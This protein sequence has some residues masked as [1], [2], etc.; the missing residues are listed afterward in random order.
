MRIASMHVQ[1]YRSLYDARI[2]FDDQTAI[3]GRNSAGKSTVLNAI[4]LFY[5]LSA[6]LSEYDYFDRESNAEIRIQITFDDL[7]KPELDAFSSYVQDGT[8][9]VAKVIT[10]G[11]VR[12]VGSRLQIAEF[13]E[14]RAMSFRDQQ[15]RV[16]ELREK[17]E[18]E[19]LAGAI[20][21]QA[22]IATM[23]EDFEAANREKC[24]FIESE[25]QFLGPTNVGGGSLDNFTRFVAV[26]AVRDARS[27]L[28]R[29]G[30]I[31]KLLDVLIL[32]QLA[33]R[34]DVKEL[35]EQYEKRAAEIYSMDNLSELKELSSSISQCLHKYA[36]GVD[37]EIDF[38]ELKAPKLPT[39]DAVAFIS[40][41]QFSCP[42]S[43]VGHGVQRA[44]ILAVLEQ[45][46]AMEAKNHEGPDGEDL[47]PDLILAIEEPELYLHPSRCRYLCKTLTDLAASRS[48]SR[49]Q[50]IYTTHSP[51]FVGV[52]RFS[53]VRIASKK[54]VEATETKQSDLHWC[55]LD[56]VV[57]MI[58]DA[59]DDGTGGNFDVSG[60]SARS[61]TTMTLPVNEGF[62]A[63]VIVLV[64]GYSDAA[65]LE[66]AA[67]CSESAWDE[68]G[69][70]V[71]PVQGKGNIDKVFAVFESLRIPTYFCFDGDSH[72]ENEAQRT[73]NAKKNRCLLRIAGEQATDFPESE[74]LDRFAVFKNDLE[75]ELKGVDSDFFTV[76]RESIAKN[77]GVARQKDALKKPAG[78]RAYIES[79]YKEGKLPDSIIDIV[80]K[81]TE[82]RSTTP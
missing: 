67:H 42:I 82:I 48:D 20:N 23:L 56:H 4:S 25:G 24:E 7:K 29:Q 27:E 35:N 5:D 36:P 17:P 28:D 14:L 39:P 59:Q 18:F 69:V 54:P 66:T 80:S 51:L 13:A 70:A 65:A 64:E 8:L 73:E 79:A 11:G 15:A 45:L 63:D 71:I 53:Q 43:H 41:E 81:I 62:F 60:F 74:V 61:E 19:G 52:E 46:A 22:A 33:E 75:H 30:A 44:V 57:Q 38:G 72:Q 47:G 78:M 50:V 34:E 21:S 9:T 49:T 68:N 77:L 12:Y 58:A 1:G 31:H 76:T 32:R 55:S 2:D 16:R 10:K 37:L 40:E 26:P 6:H 3:V